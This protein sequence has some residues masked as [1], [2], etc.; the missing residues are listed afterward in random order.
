M[1]KG[2]LFIGHSSDGK[3]KVIIGIRGKGDH[4]AMISKEEAERFA[5]H[6]LA[7]VVRMT[8]PDSSDPDED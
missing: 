8:D 3:D 4:V 5:R 2:V 1:E 6:I 7:T